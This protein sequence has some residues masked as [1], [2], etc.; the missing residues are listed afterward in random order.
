VTSA[1]FT[2][3]LGSSPCSVDMT[4]NFFFPCGSTPGDMTF[5]CQPRVNFFNL[6]GSCCARQTASSLAGFRYLHI[7]R[8]P[9]LMRHQHILCMLC[10][11]WKLS[12]SSMPIVLACSCM[13]SAAKI[14]VFGT[15]SWT[16]R[17]Q[18]S[19]P[20]THS[21][22]MLTP[23]VSNSAQHHAVCFVCVCSNSPASYIKMIYICA[24]NIAELEFLPPLIKAKVSCSPFEYAATPIHVVGTRSLLWRTMVRRELPA[25]SPHKITLPQQHVVQFESAIMHPW[26]FQVSLV[27]TLQLI[28]N[29]TACGCRADLHLLADT[30]VACWLL[31]LLVNTEPNC[32]R[33]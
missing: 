21:H 13:T 7:R 25:K 23:R 17:A 27:R 6:R 20:S 19:L 18:H 15:I 10:W 4:G 16:G 9:R 24:A 11:L 29:V 32:W 2:C 3:L 30:A 1:V 12:V 26:C 5:P 33:R 14:C 28:A 22:L 31:L 8:L